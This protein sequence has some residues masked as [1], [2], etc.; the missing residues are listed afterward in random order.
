MVELV[1]LNYLDDLIWHS[2]WNGDEVGYPDV[3][4]V[5]L[6]EFVNSETV[7]AYIDLENNKILEVF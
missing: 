3:N 1:E 6:Y 7:Y 5:G 2:D 4:V